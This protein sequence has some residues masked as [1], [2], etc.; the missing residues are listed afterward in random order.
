MDDIVIW[1]TD[2]KLH[3]QTVKRV[4]DIYKRNNVNYQ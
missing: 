1:A 3:L 2:T 4:L